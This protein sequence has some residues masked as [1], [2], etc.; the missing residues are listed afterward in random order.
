MNEAPLNVASWGAGDPVVLVH[1]GGMSSRQWKKLAERL[2]G[3]HRVLA[4]DLLG[5]GD[6][7]PW[8]ED[9]PFEF[10]MDVDALATLLGTLPKPAHLVG[11]SYGGL[12]ALTLARKYPERVRSLAVFDPVAFG[13]LHGA[14][15]TEGLS[16][17]ARA[18][19]NPVFTDERLGGSDAW[20]QAFV[21][22]WNGP[23]SWRAM[24]EPSRASFLRVGRKVFQEVRT[25]ML[26]RTGPDAYAKVTLPTL[27]MFGEKSPAAARRVVT[28][29]SQALPAATL[30]QIPGAGHMGPLTHGTLVNERIAEHL[31]RA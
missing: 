4:P 16:D 17:L 11:H 22:Y 19:E 21:D 13:V 3:T 7:P 18:A 28:L 6:N 15:D 20:M 2:A 29:L 24:P 31:A 27:L 25:L 30:V 14:Q 23:G 8:P 26:D 1:S 5:S 10:G 12:L 9:K